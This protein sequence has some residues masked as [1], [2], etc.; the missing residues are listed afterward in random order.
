[1]LTTKIQ[2]L[3]TDGL[4][5]FILMSDDIFHITLNS[6]ARESA[7]LAKLIARQYKLVSG[8]VR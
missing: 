4:D 5:F 6:D 8:A 7:L 1:V 2:K 3:E